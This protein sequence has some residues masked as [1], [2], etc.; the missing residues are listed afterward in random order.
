MKKAAGIIVKVLLGVI[1]LIIVLLFTVPILFKEQIRT[2]VEQVI[3]ESVNAVVK[4]ED[5]KLGFFRYFP[6]L[7]FS[8]NDV[9]VVGIDRFESDTLAGFKSFDL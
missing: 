8:L 4:F 5:Y 3:T 1:M 6:N 2:K 7:S 9:S